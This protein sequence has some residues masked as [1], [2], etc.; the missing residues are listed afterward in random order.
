MHGLDARR[1]VTTGIEIGSPM[2]VVD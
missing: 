1:R 2:N